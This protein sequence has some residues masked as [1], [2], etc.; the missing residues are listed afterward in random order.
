[1]QSL[2]LIGLQNLKKKLHLINAMKQLSQSTSLL[3]NE[4]ILNITKKI[5]FV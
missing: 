3:V 5:N 1:M 2:N 4:A